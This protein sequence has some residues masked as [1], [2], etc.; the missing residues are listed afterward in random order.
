MSPRVVMVLCVLV[1]VVASA[2]AFG[3][4]LLVTD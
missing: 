2:A 3:I 4:P 1:A